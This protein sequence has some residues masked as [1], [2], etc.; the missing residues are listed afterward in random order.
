VENLSPWSSLVPPWSPR[1]P[2]LTIL[3]RNLRIFPA[4]AVKLL[5]DRELHPIFSVLYAKIARGR[6]ISKYPTVF[7]TP[8]GLVWLSYHIASS[9]THIQCLCSKHY[10]WNSNAGIQLTGIHSIRWVWYW[11]PFHEVNMRVILSSALLGECGGW[12]WHLLCQVKLVDN[13]SIHQVCGC[14]TRAYCSCVYLI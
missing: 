5:P 9:A 13:T 7:A 11:L 3:W 2:L 12:Y 1:P 4:A 6:P 8:V 10:F 14:I